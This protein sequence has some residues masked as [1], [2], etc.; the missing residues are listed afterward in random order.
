MYKHANTLMNIDPY[1]M[2]KVTKVTKEEFDLFLENFPHAKRDGWGN[3]NLW[4]HPWMG[5]QEWIAMEM[6]R[7]DP[8][9][10][11]IDKSNNKFRS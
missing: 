8:I 4:R 9:E 5:K 10:Y 3:A 2:T 1:G 6:I 11:Y 7:R